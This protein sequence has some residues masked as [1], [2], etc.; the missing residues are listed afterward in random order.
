MRLFRKR[1]NEVTL[2]WPEI[3][4]YKGTYLWNLYNK[5]SKGVP[6][7]LNDGSVVAIDP[8]AIQAIN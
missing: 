2:R 1:L 8:M 6:I 5:I 7:E 4:K 3:R